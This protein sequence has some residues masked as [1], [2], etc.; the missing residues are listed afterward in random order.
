MST[1]Y[2]IKATTSE[3]LR[4]RSEVP[5]QL[6]QMGEFVGDGYNSCREHASTIYHAGG[7]TIKHYGFRDDVQLEVFGEETARDH[8]VK[9]L[10]EKV[11]LQ[12]EPIK[13][14]E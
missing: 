4:R 7:T 9:S 10:A 3:E 11:D 6:R 13:S 5:A 1:Q 12:I 2:I 8:V 14:K